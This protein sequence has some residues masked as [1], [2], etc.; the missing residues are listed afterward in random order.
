MKFLITLTI[1]GVVTYFACSM[2]STNVE[3]KRSGVVGYGQSTMKVIEDNNLQT[4]V[5]DYKELLSMIR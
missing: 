2:F 1:I 4:N 5:V 3:G